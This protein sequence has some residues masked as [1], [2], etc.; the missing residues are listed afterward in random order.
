MKNECWGEVIDLLQNQQSVD[1]LQA[2]MGVLL[3]RE[4]REAVGSRLAIMRALLAGDES[5]RD[6]ARRLGVSI[7]KVT[8]CSNYLKTLSNTE[9]TMIQP[10]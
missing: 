9:M 1:A 7:V 4:E 10:I 5:Q 8:R 3:T 6:I 2:L